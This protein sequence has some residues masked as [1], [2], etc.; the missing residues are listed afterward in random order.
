MMDSLQIIRNEHRNLYRVVHL[1]GSLARDQAAGQAPDFD[2]MTQI[3]DYL[4]TFMDRFHHP[5][6]DRYLF[7]RLRDRDPQAGAILDELEDEHRRC[8][9]GLIDLRRALEAYRAG[10][11]GAEAAF[12]EAVRTYLR[13]QTKH[14][15]K[16]DGI[17]LPMARRSLTAEDWAEIDAAFADN[18][19][20][21]FS[22]SARAETR[23]LFHRLVNAAPAPYGL[24]G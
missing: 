15:Q 20:P 4:D 1:L 23:A 2:V 12:L 19:D 22:D 18:T 3:V 14:L 6:E 9:V 17:V 7:A 24:D 21:L 16:E 8:P 10:Q 13:F 11:P 5:K